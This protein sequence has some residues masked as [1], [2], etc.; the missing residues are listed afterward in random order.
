MADTSQ[1][2]ETTP[3][4]ATTAVAEPPGPP[5]A[6][7]ATGTGATPPP[8]RKRWLGWVI[9]IVSAVVV[10]GLLVGVVIWATGRGGTKQ[11]FSA[12]RTPFESAMAKAGTKATFPDAPVELAGVS[13]TGSHPFQA[14][15][16][17]EEVT[18][19]LNVLPWTTELQG[20]SVAVSGVTVGFPDQ[21]TASLRAR[22]QV[23]GSSYSG[24]LVGPIAYRN[25]S[26]ESPG[27]TKVVAEGFTI[28]GDRAQQATDMLVLYLNAYL[29]AAP[30]LTVDTAVVTAEGVD[31]SGTSPDTL[32]L[33]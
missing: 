8:K 12:Y 16:T 17:A 33:K 26:L 29:K 10:I 27:A 18:A 19:L 14:T 6:P 28:T 21:G 13:A 2:A 11:V 20:T 15:F 32:S 4:T 24:T 25:G 22:V 9:G 23:N 7:P 31:V 30:G 3:A 1:P 5:G